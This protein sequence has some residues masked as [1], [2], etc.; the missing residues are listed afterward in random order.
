MKRNTIIWSIFGLVF[1]LFVFFIIWF[2]GFLPKY[3]WYESYSYKSD[4]PYGTKIMHDMLEKM[5]TKLDFHMIE[6]PL[7]ANFDS[8]LYNSSYIFIG[9]SFIIDS[10]ELDHLLNYVSNGND[11]LISSHETSDIL[12]DEIT[13][14]NN[15]IISYESFDSNFIQLNIDNKEFNF[16]YQF[17]EDTVNY[18]WTFIDTIKEENDN[19][20]YYGSYGFDSL[21]CYF[22]SPMNYCRIKYGNGNFFLHSV[23]LAFTNFHLLKE[24]NLEYANTILSRMDLNTIFWDE[25]HKA[26]SRFRGGS[27]IN[28][29][30]TPLKYILMQKEL[31]WGWYLGLIMVLVFILFKTKREQLAIP[32]I[33]QNINTS[34]EYAKAIGTLYFQSK[35]H[36]QIGEEMMKLFMAFIRNRYHINTHI[37]NEKLKRKIAQRS[38]IEIQHI[39]TIFKS[40][41]KVR[42]SP[43]AN[44]EALITYYRTLQYF[45]KNCK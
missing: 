21:G 17:I 40:N 7:F 22:D 44:N 19:Y 14:N 26:P 11:V 10:L 27:G 36:K 39:E 43:V 8:N 9:A 23:P 33:E 12:L 31:R 34:I 35:D 18:R 6:K 32:V 45:Y 41:I 38:E 25:Y 3:T 30:E 16:Y 29:S 28:F 24:K 4:Q 5:V 37:D 20:Y 2:R 13:K 42:Y 1:L 15:L